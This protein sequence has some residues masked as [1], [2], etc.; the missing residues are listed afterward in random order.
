MKERETK[1]VR[2]RQGKKHR[3]IEGEETIFPTV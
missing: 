2:H 3:N 1:E